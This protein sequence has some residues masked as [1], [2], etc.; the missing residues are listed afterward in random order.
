MMPTAPP[1]RSRWYSKR[2]TREAIAGYLFIMPWIL[3]FVIFVVGPMIASAYISMTRYAIAQPPEFI[4]LTNYHRAFFD[5]PNFWPSLRRTATYALLAVP[6]GV[7]G[8]LLLATLLNQDIRGKALFRTLFYIPTLVPLV[9]SGVLWTWLLQPEVGLVNNTLWQLGIAGP[10]WLGDPS[11]ALYCIVAIV[12]WGSIG[13]GRM[14]TFLAALQDVPKELQEACELDGGGT[15]A[16]FRNVTIPMISPVI[17]F[18]LVLG[19]LDAVG[20]FAIAYVATEGGPNFA[21]WFYMLHLVNQ[22]LRFQDMG[23]ASAL[24]WIFFVIVLVITVVQVRLSRAWVYY[25]GGEEERG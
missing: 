11:L 1:A 23:Y 22:A 25:A 19:V 5:D 24:A 6:L 2:S 13:G 14:I 18:N 4:G 15:W 3:G 10:G 16:K 20:V 12:L 21:T 7:A 8:S 9:A 17:F